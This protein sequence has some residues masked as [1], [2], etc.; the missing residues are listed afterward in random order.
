MRTGESL[1]LI[2]REEVFYFKSY[3]TRTFLIIWDEMFSSGLQGQLQ[4]AESCA[5]TLLQDIWPAHTTGGILSSFLRLQFVCR[6]N[7][8]PAPS[9]RSRAETRSRWFGTLRSPTGNSLS[10]QKS[11]RPISSQE[12]SLSFPLLDFFW[13]VINSFILIRRHTPEKER[14]ESRRRSRGRTERWKQCRR[15]EDRG[16]EWN[17]SPS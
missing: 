9:V 15:W 16:D 11:P 8:S 2:I 12:V 17:R 13:S 7:L 1:I 10:S 3:E 6:P 5:V 14:E 4:L